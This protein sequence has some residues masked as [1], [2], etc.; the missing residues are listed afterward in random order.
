MRNLD[1]VSSPKAA[2][3]ARAAC[4]QHAHPR[5]CSLMQGVSTPGKPAAAGNFLPA[6]QLFLLPPARVAMPRSHWE[7]NKAPGKLASHFLGRFAVDGL[8]L[9]V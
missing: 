2:S 3:K 8:V 7:W 6:L 9:D 4:T 1:H 5:R